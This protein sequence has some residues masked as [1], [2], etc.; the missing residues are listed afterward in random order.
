MRDKMGINKEVFYPPS[1]YSMPFGPHTASYDYSFINKNGCCRVGAGYFEN[2]KSTEAFRKFATLK[3]YPE[4]SD[5]K[6]ITC[7]SPFDGGYRVCR[8][9]PYGIVAPPF[10]DARYDGEILIPSFPVSILAQ[11]TYDTRELEQRVAEKAL[12]YIEDSVNKE[13]TIKMHQNM[14][15]YTV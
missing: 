15:I 13:V 4:G 14:V 10:T 9:K 3:I 11:E 8:R 7:Y 2:G 12:R 1:N 6:G 5:P